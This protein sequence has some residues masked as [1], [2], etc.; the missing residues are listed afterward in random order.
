[1]DWH[2]NREAAKWLSDSSIQSL[3]LH[4]L[5]TLISHASSS[6]ILTT[7][8]APIPKITSTPKPSQVPCSGLQQLHHKTVKK[9]NSKLLLQVCF[10]KV[11]Y[12]YFTPSLIHDEAVLIFKCTHGLVSIEKIN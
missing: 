1:M 10:H 11:V 8:L 7:F 4:Q 3:L 12:K 6:T 9:Q 2:G 5:Q